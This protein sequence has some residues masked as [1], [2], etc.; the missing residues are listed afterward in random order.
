MLSDYI[1]KLRSSRDRI[2]ILFIQY[3]PILMIRYFS[4]L[5]LNRIF[6]KIVYLSITKAGRN[7]NIHHSS[8]IMGVKGISI[9]DNFFSGPRLWM[10]AVFFHE[11]G[12]FQPSLEIGNRVV[13]NSNVH[14]ACV[15]HL[16]IEDDV[17]IASGVF[18]SDHNHGNYSGAS[19]HSHPNTPPNDRTVTSDGPVSIGSGC[20]IGENAVI[21]SG[22][23]IGQGSIIGANSVVKGII[24]PWSI[25]VGA[26]AKVI[27][28][29]DGKQLI[30]KRV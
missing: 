29:F 26:P 20:W 18:I 17:L 16:V 2:S 13:L 23:K 21:L 24:P 6:S 14:I 12:V 3:G 30:W 9:G 5:I 22:T 11:T 8:R 27:K 10:E 19:N 25:A 15:N 4:Q 7:I 28:Q 1:Q